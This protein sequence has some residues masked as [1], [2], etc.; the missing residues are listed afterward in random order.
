MGRSQPAGEAELL[1]DLSWEEVACLY[2]SCHCKAQ[3]ATRTK[4][5][6]VAVLSVRLLGTCSTHRELKLGEENTP[7]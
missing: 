7:A 5:A 4:C 2:G 1:V 3:L 6:F